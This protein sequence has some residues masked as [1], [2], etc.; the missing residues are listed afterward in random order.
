MLNAGHG[1]SSIGHHDLAR[2]TKCPHQSWYSLVDRY[3][4]YHNAL[5]KSPHAGQGWAVRLVVMFY[6]EGS[7]PIRDV[8]KSWVDE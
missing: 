3:E 5:A 6:R 1:S 4:Q 2:R 7:F 8:H